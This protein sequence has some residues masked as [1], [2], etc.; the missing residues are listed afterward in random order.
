MTSG[1]VASLIGLILDQRSGMGLGCCG[2][3]LTDQTL[4]SREGLS[5]NV[6]FFFGGSKFKM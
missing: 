5:D 6:V 4:T 3:L 1:T 2:N